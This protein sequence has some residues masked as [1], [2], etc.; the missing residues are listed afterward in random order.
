MVAPYDDAFYDVAMRSDGLILMSILMHV[1]DDSHSFFYD[2]GCL[3][4]ACCCLLLE[5]LVDMLL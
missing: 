3:I 5:V 4:L 1:H 2:G